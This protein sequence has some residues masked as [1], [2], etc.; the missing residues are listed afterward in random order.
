[1]F[2]DVLA[3]VDVA[4]QLMFFFFFFVSSFRVE[5]PRRVGPVSLAVR[6]RRWG[7]GRGRGLGVGGERGRGFTG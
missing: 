7:G 2:Q 5:E 3:N 4:F 6:G 1:M